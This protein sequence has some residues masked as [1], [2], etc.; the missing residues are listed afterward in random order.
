MDI[1]QLR[2]FEAVARHRHFTR[3]ADELHVA[4]SALSHQI[5]QL[6]RELGVELLQRTTRSVQLTDAGELVT[7]RA[8]TLISEL[9]ALRGEIDELRGLVR[10]HVTVGAHLFGGQLDIPAVLY[11]FTAAHPGIEIGLREGTAQRMTEM[12]ED[13]S[14]DVSF[15]LEA[16]TPVDV[17]RV[18]LSSEEL[19]VAMSPRHALGGDGPL[20]IE[21]LEGHRLIAFQRGSSTRQVVD[22]ALS[23]AHIEPPIALEAN[24]F[25]LVRGLVARGV[26]LAILP[27][28]FLELPGPRIAFRP[29][30]PTL[31]MTVALWWRRGRRLSPAAQAFVQFVAAQRA[32]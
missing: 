23:A 29:L 15:A 13:G 18:E 1:R 16:E 2:Y 22:G 10:G 20:A 12:L 8:R 3:A 14:L 21:Q 19:A 26:G 30:T 4:Q 27:R 31:R 17:E 9:D 24:D 7:S 32:A 11:R 25:A 28:S 5:R 6:E